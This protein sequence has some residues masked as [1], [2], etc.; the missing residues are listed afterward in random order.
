MEINEGDKCMKIL[1]I[2]NSLGSGG[3]EKL[4]EEM[5][6]LMNEYKDIEADVML[7]SDKNN[8]FDKNLKNRNVKIIISPLKKLYNPLNIYYIRKCIIENQYDIVHVHLFPAFYWTSLASKLI[9][10]NKP[11]FI[12]TEHSTHN[13]RR[14]KKCLRHLEK[15]IYSN[16]DKIISVSQQ[17]QDNLISWIKPKQS[18]LNKFIVIENGINVDKFKHALP[19]KKSEI[20]SQFTDDT[21]LLCMVGRFSKQKDQSTLIKAMKKLPLNVHLLLVGEGEL[22]HQNEELTKELGVNNRVHFLGFRNDVER[23]LKTCDIVVL[24]TNWEG[25]SL[26]SIEGMASERPFLASRVQGIKKIVDGY[27]LLFEQGNVEQLSNLIKKILNDDKLYKEITNRCIKR[28]EMYCID[29]TVRAII[30]LYKYVL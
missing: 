16:Y 2:I 10:K 24:S 3:A 11:K 17:V 9:L 5:L 22:K 29:N 21:K 1:H 8:V 30:D 6:P 14:D 26:A 15:F 23:I 19:Y 20:C 4:I 27:G 18:K 13:R 28:A 12:M 7:L 25:L